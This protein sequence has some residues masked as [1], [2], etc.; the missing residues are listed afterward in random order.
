[1]FG[2]LKSM[3][4]VFHYTTGI[5]IESKIFPFVYHR[6]NTQAFKKQNFSTQM[7]KGIKINCSKIEKDKN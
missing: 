4:N 1:M 7:I 6:L 2:K 3:F 5:L